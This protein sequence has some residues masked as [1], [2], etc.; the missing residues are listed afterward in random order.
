MWTIKAQCYLLEQQSHE[1]YLKHTHKM[2]KKH[3]RHNPNAI[4]IQHIC[5]CMQMYKYTY[6]KRPNWIHD[7][8]HRTK[9]QIESKSSKRIT[10]SKYSRGAAPRHSRIQEIKWRWERLAFTAFRLYRF[11][12]HFHC[13]YISTAHIVVDVMRSRYICRLGER[14]T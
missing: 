11:Y 7:T 8:I 10:H 4:Y 14:H 3:R 6:T 13:I 12:L 5:A 1:L 2:K 9:K